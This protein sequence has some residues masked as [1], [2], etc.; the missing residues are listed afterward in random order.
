MLDKRKRSKET[1]FV[2]LSHFHTETME[3]LLYMNVQDHS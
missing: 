1:E 3:R 2:G